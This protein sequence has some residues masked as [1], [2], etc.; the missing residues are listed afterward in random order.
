MAK[1]DPES[2]SPTATPTDNSRSGKSKPILKVIEETCQRCMAWDDQPR[3]CQLVHCRTWPFRTGTDPWRKPPTEA[4][5]AVR[6]AQAHKLNAG[7]PPSRPTDTSAYEGEVS[8][9]SCHKRY[10]SGGEESA[11]VELAQLPARRPAAQALPDEPG[12]EIR[13]GKKVGRDPSNM[14]QDELRALGHEPI[15]PRAALL[16]QC[17]M[18]TGKINPRASCPDASCPA[19]SHLMGEA[20]KPRS[21]KQ[22]AASKQQGKRLRQLAQGGKPEQVKKPDDATLKESEGEVPE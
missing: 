10:G 16:K 12:L 19:R 5:L 8:L 4:Q 2:Y 20:R 3:N 9:A 7:T 1:R 14:T 6:R 15:T 17:R 11:L 13:G 21:E 18:C 22:K